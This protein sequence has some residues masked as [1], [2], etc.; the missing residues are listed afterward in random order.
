MILGVGIEAVEI[1]RF[2]KAIER[3]GERLVDRLFTKGEIAWCNS[4]KRPEVHLSVRFAAKVSLFK[5][6]GRTLRFKDV[7]VVKD[8]LGRPSFM[9]TAIG[10]ESITLSMTHDAGVSLAQTIVETR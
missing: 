5:A 1:S 9:G 8:A 6:L 7:E 4:Q 10:P 3:R 2:K